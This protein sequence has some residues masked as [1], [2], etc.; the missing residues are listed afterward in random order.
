MKNVYASDFILLKLACLLGRWQSLSSIWS[1]N[2]KASVTSLILESNLVILGWIEF[3]A[4]NF[5]TQN[6]AQGPEQQHHLGAL[7]N[8]LFIYVFGCIS[9]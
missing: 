9:S 2:R 7:K 8:Y 1:L 6:V 4:L 5:S 3:S